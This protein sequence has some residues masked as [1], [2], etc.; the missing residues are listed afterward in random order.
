MEFQ[1]MLLISGYGNVLQGSDLG[2]SIID[3]PDPIATGNELSYEIFVKNFGIQDA[4][5][6]VLTDLIPG[7]VDFLNASSAKGGSCNLSGDEI[8]CNIGDLA[9]GETDTIT[10]VVRPTAEG[11]ISNTAT[12]AATEDDLVTENNSASA[13]TTVLWNIPDIIGSGHRPSMAT[14]ANGKVHVS[15]VSDIWM[16]AK[17]KPTF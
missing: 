14:D 8:I 13:E 5:N 9:N 16:R 2:V 7:N 6:V 3:S 10:I 1:T 17:E 15:Y 4:T 11:I 12:V